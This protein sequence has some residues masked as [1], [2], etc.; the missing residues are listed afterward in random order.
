MPCLF[1]SSIVKFVSFLLVEVNSTN[2]PLII[3]EFSDQEDLKFVLSNR[4][5][6]EDDDGLLLLV[7]GLY[8][9]W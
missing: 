4:D 6:F 9:I 3:G 8:G 5:D 2:L 7:K 1:K